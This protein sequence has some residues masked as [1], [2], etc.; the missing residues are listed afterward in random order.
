VCYQVLQ[1]AKAFRQSPGRR[2]LNS[3]PAESARVNAAYRK[4]LVTNRYPSYVLWSCLRHPRRLLLMSGLS[5]GPMLAW[6]FAY[7]LDCA[8]VADQPR[9]TGCFAISDQNP[10]LSLGRQPRGTVSGRSM[11]PFAH[12]PVSP[13]VQRDFIVG[14]DQ[15][16]IHERIAKVGSIREFLDLFDKVR[17]EAPS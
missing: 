11:A 15:R 13:P 8:F 2:S 5:R 1:A 9:G 6:C 16:A 12:T 14:H 17:T 10:R 4:R 3:Q 7:Y